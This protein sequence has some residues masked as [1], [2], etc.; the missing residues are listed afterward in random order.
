MTVAAPPQTE[1][2]FQAAVID[3]ARRNL[4]RVHHHHDSRRQVRPGVLVGD[5][6]A[7][8]YPDLTCVRERVLWAELK[9]DGGRLSVA[10]SAWINALRDAGQEAY[11]WRPSDWL[12]IERV[13]GRE[14]HGA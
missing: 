11:I 13:L 9:R 5:R 1:A 12:E 4:W 3:Y 8:G 7:S 2:Q 6:D 10:Q 14:R